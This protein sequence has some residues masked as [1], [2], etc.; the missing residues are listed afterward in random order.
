MICHAGSDPPAPLA[1][2]RWRR[3]WLLRTAEWARVW[4][5]LVL[6]SLLLPCGVGRSGKV[7]AFRWVGRVRR[8]V[9]VYPVSAVAGISCSVCGG[10]VVPS[11]CCWWAKNQERMPDGSALPHCW[12][13]ALSHSPI[14]M[15]RWSPFPISSE[16]A[17]SSHSIVI[18][19]CDREDVFYWPLGCL[20]CWLHD[21][22]GDVCGGPGQPGAERPVYRLRSALL[23]I[24]HQTV[25]GRLGEW[26]VMTD[27]LIGRRKAPC[28]QDL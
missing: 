12:S 19:L 7:K 1:G 13:V 6:N 5:S 4:T 27:A 2:W 9:D 16:G 18:L 22:T 20:L 24:G 28:L 17:S 21:R 10:Y 15:F 26:P 8:W 11:L 14:R 3:E 25:G 23:Q